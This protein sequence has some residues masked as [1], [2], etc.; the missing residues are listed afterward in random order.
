MTQFAELAQA[1]SLRALEVPPCDR[2][3]F[4]EFCDLVDAEIAQHT[5]EVVVLGESMGAGVAIAAHKSCA[6]YT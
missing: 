5:G 3:S 6:A 1:Y 2:S 4:D